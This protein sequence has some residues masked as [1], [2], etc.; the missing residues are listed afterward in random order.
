MI[1]NLIIGSVFFLQL[2][3]ACAQEI[4]KGQEIVELSRSKL[5]TGVIAEHEEI[6]LNILDR[7]RETEKQLDRWVLL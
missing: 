7:G 3:N 1:L 2:G 6:K 5:R 4:D